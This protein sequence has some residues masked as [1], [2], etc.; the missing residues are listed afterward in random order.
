MNSFPHRLTHQIFPSLL[1]QDNFLFLDLPRDR[2]SIWEEDCWLTS[3]SIS[4]SGCNLH[5]SSALK[6]SWQWENCDHQSPLFLEKGKTNL[7]GLLLRSWP[8]F[9]STRILKDP[10]SNLLLLACKIC[11]FARA[12]PKK[13]WALQEL[14]GPWCLADPTILSQVS[15]KN[16]F[17]KI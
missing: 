5:S 6:K 13:G 11:Y 4:Y 12:S 16:C 1:M 7:I 10:K 3:S 14:A 17:P 2:F 15:S 9:S 8:S